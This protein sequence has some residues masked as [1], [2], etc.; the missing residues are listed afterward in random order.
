MLGGGVTR[1][2]HFR[3]CWTQGATEGEALANA[4]EAIPEYLSAR[5]ELLKGNEARELEI[6][7]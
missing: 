7:V 6:A 4:K 2:T 1:M 3:G 5:D